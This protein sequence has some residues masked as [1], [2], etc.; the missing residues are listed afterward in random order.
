LLRLGKYTGYIAEAKTIEGT[1]R[2]RQGQ[3][4]DIGQP[5]ASAGTADRDHS[6][7]AARRDVRA[8][9]SG[10]R[11]HRLSRARPRA[12]RCRS[13]RSVIGQ[14]SRCVQPTAAVASGRF[15]VSGAGEPAPKPVLIFATGN[16]ARQAFQ[17]RANAPSC[18]GSYLE[19]TCRSFMERVKTDVSANCCPSA[20]LHSA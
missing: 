12:R 16:A 9:G 2:R 20:S 11:G 14:T 7:L 15:L 1:A 4:R 6:A 13:K 3:E 17:M 19:S 5:V 10:V 18:R 8:A